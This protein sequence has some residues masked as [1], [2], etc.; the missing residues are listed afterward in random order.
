TGRNKIWPFG[1]AI[2]PLCH[3]GK[4]GICRESASECGWRSASGSIFPSLR[5][6]V[7]PPSPA[8]RPPRGL[9]GAQDDLAQVTAGGE[10]LVGGGDLGER[11]LGLDRDPEAAVGD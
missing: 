7:R 4:A 2:V 1:S 5:S 11:E 3:L 8:S 9:R 10:P 6:R